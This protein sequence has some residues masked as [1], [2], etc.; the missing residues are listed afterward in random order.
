MIGKILIY[1]SFATLLIS[2]VLF[3]ITTAYNNKYLLPAKRLYNLSFIIIAATS[4]FFMVNIFAHNFSYTYIFHYSSRYLPG[5]LLLSAFYSGQ[6]GSFLLWY[7]LQ[8]AL[9]YFMLKFFLDKEKA[10]TFMAVYSLILLFF[11]VLLMAKSPFEYFWDTYAGKTF[12]GQE[13]TEGFIPPDGSGLN[14]ILK[15]FWNVIHPPVLFLGYVLLVI[16]YTYAISALISGKHNDWIKQA[17]RWTVLGSGILGL[18]IALGAFWSYE[19]LGWGGFWA[20]DPVE[21]SSLIPWLFSLALIHTMII[22]K[23]ENALIKTN[24]FLAIV[25]YTF[26]IFATFLTRS[27]VLGDVSVHSFTSA[28]SVVYI[29][30]LLFF[31]LLFFVGI[32]LL[33]VKSKEASESAR[34]IEIKTI[35]REFMLILGALIISLSSVIILFGT[36][37]PIISGALGQAKATFE[38]SF[39]DKVNTPI[40]ILVFI[41]SSISFVINWKHDTIKKLLGK[42]AISL[43]VA[44]ISV[45]I[46]INYG[47]KRPDHLVILAFAFFAIVMNIELIIRNIKNTKK[48]GGLLAHFGTAVLIIGAVFSGGYERTEHINLIPG[49]PDSALGFKVEFIDKAEI[50]KHNP[51]NKKFRYNISLEKNGNI[52]HSYPVYYWSN[53]NNMQSPF[54]QPGIKSLLSGDIYLSPSSSESFM[55]VNHIILRKGDSEKVPLDSSISVKLIKLQMLREQMPPTVNALIEINGMPDTLLL[56]QENPI[57]KKLINSNIEVG[58]PQI[59]PNEEDISLSEVVIIFKKFGD[60]LP[61]PTEIFTVSLSFKPMIWLVWAGF[62]IIIAG[63]FIA[64]IKK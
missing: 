23:R 27:G 13:V 56:W 53:F 57:W 51:N 42:S 3:V 34:K 17:Y 5:H 55:D 29:V 16:P 59:L 2:V 62:I 28:G 46:F 32:V 61:Q 9:G 50:D 40:I 19:T 14:P 25:T 8:A 22:Q 18:G 60:P 30:L 43:V 20:W 58:F 41:I 38:P 12:S 33:I 1:I 7:L 64:I 24:Y 63:F 54:A 37:W 11:A 4:F 15:N 10:P 31:L 39:Y 45:I 47:I 44:I 48:L 26:V 21:N 52:T 49:K 36:L 6:E 35:S